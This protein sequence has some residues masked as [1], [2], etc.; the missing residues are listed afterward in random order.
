MLG[1]RV[2]ATT[3][4]QSSI[5][6]IFFWADQGQHGTG[7]GGQNLILRCGGKQ[8]NFMEETTCKVNSMMLGI[9]ISFI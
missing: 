4:N 8:Q 9:C 3:M 6:L 7:G 1:P 2:V 5:V